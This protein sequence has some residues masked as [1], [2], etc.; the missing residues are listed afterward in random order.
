MRANDALGAR[1][2]DYFER[3][4]SNHGGH[5]SVPY[6]AY[7]DDSWVKRVIYRL[8]EILGPQFFLVRDT[9]LGG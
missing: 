3:L 4:W 5:F 2:S 7:T 9:T 1:V 6:E 8:Q